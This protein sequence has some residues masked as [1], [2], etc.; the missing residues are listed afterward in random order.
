M[1]K[2][3][4]IYE[5]LAEEIRKNFRSQRELTSRDLLYWCQY[6]DSVGGR[7]SDIDIYL[8]LQEAFLRVL[9]N[10]ATPE[11]R[12]RIRSVEVSSVAQRLPG[13][14]FGSAVNSVQIVFTISAN[15]QD[16]DSELTDQF[17]LSVAELVEKSTANGV[18][19]TFLPGAVDHPECVGPTPAINSIPI[20]GEVS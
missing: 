13:I 3:K 16:Y 9:G 2:A 6:D 17:I 1:S 18:L 14:P 8:G 20:V 11:T 5:R 15:Q 10:L 7:C 19:Y 4:A 12:R